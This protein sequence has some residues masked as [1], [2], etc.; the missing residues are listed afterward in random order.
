MTISGYN[1][2]IALRLLGPVDMGPEAA[3]NIFVIV[4]SYISIVLQR[5]FNMLFRDGKWYDNKVGKELVIT[6]HANPTY[7]TFEIFNKIK[8]LRDAL[9]LREVGHTG[10]SYAHD[11]PKLKNPTIPVKSS[12]EP[13]PDLTAKRKHV[14]RVTFENPDILEAQNATSA[15]T[16][17]K[18]SIDKV[19]SEIGEKKNYLK[20]RENQL[21]IL[22]EDPQS[23]T[24]DHFNVL[25]E[26][27]IEK[28][29][30]QDY[31]YENQDTNDSKYK[32]KFKNI[33]IP[34]KGEPSIWDPVRTLRKECL[35]RLTDLDNFYL[36]E[37]RER[38]NLTTEDREKIDLLMS[39]E[40]IMEAIATILRKVEIKNPEKA[41]GILETNTI[42]REYLLK[43]SKDL[44][45]FLPTR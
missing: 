25:Q 8:A 20:G 26:Y 32:C 33:R 24:L 43:N 37:E 17:I 28:R 29:S 36:E 1:P 23:K 19:I 30:L 40:N 7:Q 14:K 12:E 5:I 2:D 10:R 21:K 13:L 39:H 3:K 45:I 44:T 18:E 34:D 27:A 6:Y 35:D 38:Q 22:K 31:R 41:R 42:M 16:H 11:L 4:R 15:L 9:L